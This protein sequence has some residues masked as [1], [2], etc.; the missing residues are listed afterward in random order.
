MKHKAIHVR[1]D[2]EI[3]PGALFLLHRIIIEIP[4]HELLEPRLQIGGRPIPELPV[5]QTYIGV[6]KLHIPISGHL[7]HLPLSP[8]LQKLFQYAYKLAYRHRCR[9]PQVEDPQ[10]RR[11][12]LLPTTP[13]AL[14]RRV[15]RRQAPL[16]NVINVREIP[17]HHAMIRCLEYLNWLPPQNI[18]R[19]EEIRHVWPTPRPVHREKPQPSNRKPV[20]MII[21]VRN[22]LTGLLRCRVQAR[23]LV[24]PVLFRKGYLGIQPVD[25]TRRRPHDRWLRIRRLADF[26]EVHE[27]SDVAVHVGARVLHRVAH[28]GL[29]RQVHHVGERHDVEELLEE[30]RVVDVSLHDE[31]PSAVQEPLARALEVRVV[32][33]VEAVDAKHAVAAPL[34]SH[35]DVGPNETGRPGDENSHTG[36]RAL[37]GRAAHPAL[38]V[39]AAPGIG[40]EGS[41]RR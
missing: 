12:L 19:E 37:A 14:P 13:S 11:A 26:Q 35:G 7:Q 33:V 25:R 31:H 36:L 32:V 6:C 27:P 29:R 41:A 38:P 34:E 17:R 4:P 18:L 1:H 39:A 20:Y 3:S 28:T 10:L 22:F 16:H 5:R 8:H 2:S 30:R 24:S 40:A 15:Q 23:R 9:I 21:G